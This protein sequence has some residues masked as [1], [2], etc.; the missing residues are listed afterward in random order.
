MICCAILVGIIGGI[1]YDVIEQSSIV[2]IDNVQASELVT[3]QKSVQV[4]LEVY[5]D[6]TPERIEQEIRTVF[7]ETPNTAVAIAKCE[8][9]LRPVIQ[10]H[11]IL[12][13]GRELS[14][15]IFQIHKPVWHKVA[16]NLGY[17]NY[18]TDVIDNLKMARY[19]YDQK[20]QRWTDWTCYTSGK[21][22]E[23]L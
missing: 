5:V 6:W 19:I 9:G 17:D 21:W 10:S 15:G 4:M 3:E 22:R 2:V 12:D 13:Y 23:Y 11:H 20:G 18:Q 7:H 1:F 16:L 8:S 14:F